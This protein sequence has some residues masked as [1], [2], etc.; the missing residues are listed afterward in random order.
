MSLIS[1]KIKQADDRT[2]KVVDVPEW[3][4]KLLLISPTVTENAAMVEQYTTW[5]EDVDGSM[6]ANIDRSSMAPALVVCCAHDPETRERAFVLTDID[7]L[8]EKAGAVVARV[9]RECWP[10]VGWTEIPGDTATDLGKGASSTTPPSGT[11]SDSPAASA[12]P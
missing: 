5:V 7:M 3:D 9:A 12:A 1:E 11:S 2:E 6:Q 8:R 10:L 4:V